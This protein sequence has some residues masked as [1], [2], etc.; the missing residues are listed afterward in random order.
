M[1]KFGYPRSE[2][3]KAK[4]DLEKIFKEGKWLSVGNIRVVWLPD[5]NSTKVGVSVSKR[6]HKKAVN[7]NRIKRL[8]REVYRLNKTILH[9]K[10]G[11]NFHIMMFWTSPH[12]PK[13]LGEVEKQYK[14]IC[15]K[16]LLLSN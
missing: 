1:K 7:R 12:L 6:Y 10:F 13:D 15:N 2:K 8:L 11:E 14:K 3:L 4:K 16:N 5:D 9:D